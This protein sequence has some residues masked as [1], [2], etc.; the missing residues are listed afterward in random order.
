MNYLPYLLLQTLSVYNLYKTIKINENLSIKRMKTYCRDYLCGIADV[1]KTRQ[2]P[3]RCGV[4]R[5]R[6]DLSPVIPL[7]SCRFLAAVPVFPGLPKPQF[8][9]LTQGSQVH[10]SRSHLPL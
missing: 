5:F 3:R 10:G 1:R 8:S 7:Q 2:V 4:Q 9:L 6:S